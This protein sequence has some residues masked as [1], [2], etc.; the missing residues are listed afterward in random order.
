MLL[1]LFQS[2]G[3]TKDWRPVIFAEQFGADGSGFQS[4]GVTKVWRLLLIAADV[5]RNTGGFQ[6]IGIT[7]DWRP[8]T[9][10]MLPLRT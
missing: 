10:I 9:A 3:V 6:S 1:A 8:E 2:I 4:V 7:K 5:A